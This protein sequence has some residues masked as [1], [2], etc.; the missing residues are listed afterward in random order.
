MS[1]ATLTYMRVASVGRDAH[2]GL[3]YFHSWG[4]GN[5]ELV[6]RDRDHAARW[7][8]SETAAGRP[9][10]VQHA[11]IVSEHEGLTAGFPQSAAD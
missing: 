1:A 6:F 11:P 4:T 8:Q 7:T 2:D 10:T 9:T 5:Q 3:L